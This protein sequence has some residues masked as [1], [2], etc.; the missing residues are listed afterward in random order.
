[1]ELVMGLFVLLVLNSGLSKCVRMYQR[2]E[3]VKKCEMCKQQMKN[4]K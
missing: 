4:G 1:M 3:A 2:L